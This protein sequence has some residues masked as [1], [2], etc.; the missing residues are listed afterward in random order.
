[1]SGKELTPEELEELKNRHIRSFVLRRGH[2]SVAQ[3]RAFEE[4]FPKYEVKYE[5]KPFDAEAAFGRAKRRPLSRRL[6]RKLTSW[7]V[8][9]SL[10]AW[11]LSANALTRWGLKTSESPGT[12][13]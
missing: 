9:F 8:K 11:V 12:T 1:M 13:P 10:R 2:I 7:A 6:I 5:V 4:I 3:E